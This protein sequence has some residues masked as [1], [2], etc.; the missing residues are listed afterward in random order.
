MVYKVNYTL[1]S[2]INSF[3]TCIIIVNVFINIFVVV[4][5]GNSWTLILGT[6]DTY[7]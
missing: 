1:I 2:F 7:K 4:N 3:S 6:Y 5:V